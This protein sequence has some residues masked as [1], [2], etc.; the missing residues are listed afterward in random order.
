MGYESFRKH[1]LM[2]DVY[3][4][5]ISIK[6]AYILNISQIFFSYFRLLLGTVSERK[7]K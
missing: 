4:H 7:M 6:N 5:K 3:E 1:L 2:N